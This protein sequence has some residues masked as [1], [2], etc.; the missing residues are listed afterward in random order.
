MHGG[1]DSRV[2]PKGGLGLFE[3]IG[4]WNKSLRI[5]AG[6]CREVFNEY[7]KGAIIEDVVDWLN[8]HADLEFIDFEEEVED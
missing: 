7:G 3:E 1:D 6:L 2:S 8:L 5:Y 4:A